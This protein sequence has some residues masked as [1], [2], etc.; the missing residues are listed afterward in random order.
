MNMKHNVFKWMS[1]LVMVLVMAFA[2]CASAE[3]LLGEDAVELYAEGAMAAPADVVSTWAVSNF[4][5]YMVR[6]LLA[7]TTQID[8]RSFD[9]LYSEF[10][11]MYQDVLNKHPELFNVSS[12]ISYYYTEKED[13]IHITS[14]LPK[15]KYSGDELTQMTALYNSG[16]SAI[17]DYA[18]QAETDVGRLMRASDYMCANY[19]YDTRVYSTD[20]S[21]KAL[22]VYSPE[23]FFKEGVGVC[24]AYMLVYRAVLNELGFENTTATSD[25]MNHIWNLVSLDGSWFHVDVTWNDALSNR[26]DMPLR[27]MHKYFLLSDDGITAANHYDWEATVT[28]DDVTYDEYFWTFLKYPAPMLG[29]VVYYADDSEYTFTPTLCTHDL[30][31]GETTE[32]FT[33]RLGSGSAFKGNHPVWVTDKLVYYVIRD[34]LYAADYDG[35]NATVVYETGSTQNW[36][37]AMYQEDDTLYMHVIDYTDAN[38]PG[39]VHTY[40]LDTLSFDQDYVDVTVG[41]QMP[42]GMVS[43]G[44]PTWT[45]SNPDVVSVSEQGV[46]TAHAIGSA[47]ITATTENL[48]DSITIVVHS[49]TPMVLPADALTIEASA[50]AGTPVEEITLPEGVTSIGAQAFANCPNLK[51]VNLPASLTAEAIAADAFTGSPIS[52]LV[53]ANDALAAYAQTQTLNWVVKPA[54]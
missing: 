2:A 29:D 42:I 4:E 9:L 13:G 32:L 14:L 38:H 43:T 15:Y 12:G 48:E 31:T 22:T 11:P 28:A 50:F 49:K 20:S 40:E 19:A 24:Q 37:Y 18:K 33:Y 39:S 36:I 51:L 53:C 10:K 21:E 52:V 8:L 17:L 27:A 47:V 30:A 1:L 7:G 44:T 46:A 26:Q 35:S 54:E 3:E 5:E 23:L 41:D 16:V 25:A 34:K 45:S 6:Q